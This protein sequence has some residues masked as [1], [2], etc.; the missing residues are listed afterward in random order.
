[1]L[2][3]WGSEKLTPF[4]LATELEGNPT[5]V[6]P[7]A[8]R[9]RKGPQGLRVDRGGMGTVSSEDLGN[10]GDTETGRWVAVVLKVWERSPSL[11]STT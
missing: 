2:R 1:M 6:E 3:T 8:L 11:V 7:E 10:L 9:A 5:A 4:L